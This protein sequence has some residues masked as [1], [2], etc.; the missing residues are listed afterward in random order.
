L[1]ALP[2]Q[3]V[4]SGQGSVSTRDILAELPA[5]AEAVASGALRIVARAVPLTDVAAVWPDTGDA[6]RIVLTP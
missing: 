1:R 2:L 6:A 4:G 3:I 5:I